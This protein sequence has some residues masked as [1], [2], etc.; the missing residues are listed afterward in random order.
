MP[1]IAVTKAYKATQTVP[2]LTSPIGDLLLKIQ[3][4]FIF[5]QFLHVILYLL[6]LLYLLNLCFFFRKHILIDLCM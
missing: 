3:T 1:N 4:T 5:S 2:K 6:D